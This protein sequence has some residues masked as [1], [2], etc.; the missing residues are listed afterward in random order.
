MESILE[1][2]TE[3]KPFSKSNSKIVHLGTGSMVPSSYRNVT[4][5]LI[6]F[7]HYNTGIIFDCGEGTFVKSL[8]IMNLINIGKC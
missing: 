7:P 2:K 5:I 6:E 8:P 4:G 3:R 1:A